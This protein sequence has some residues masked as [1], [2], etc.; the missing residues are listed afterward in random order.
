MAEKSGNLVV[1]DT[2]DL[3]SQL[4]ADDCKIAEAAFDE[5]SRRIDDVKGRIYFV[6]NRE[7]NGDSLCYMIELLGESKDPRFFP[8]LAK[9]LRSTHVR[10][11]F[12]AHAALLRLGTAESRELHY[13]CNLRQLLSNPATNPQHAKKRPKDANA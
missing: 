6:A 10:V 13:R 9:Q 11:R 1:V 12:F 4:A 8:F 3:I 5:L 7:S 2:D